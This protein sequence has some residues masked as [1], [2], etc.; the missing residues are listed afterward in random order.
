MDPWIEIRVLALAAAELKLLSPA[1]RG[2]G[3]LV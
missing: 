1:R 2:G 3:R